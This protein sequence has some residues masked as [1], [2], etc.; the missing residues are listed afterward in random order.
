MKRFMFLRLNAA[1]LAAAA[2]CGALAQAGPKAIQPAPKPVQA[3]SQPAAPGLPS[4]TP[5]P[6]P[7]T[8]LLAGV[9]SQAARLRS[10]PIPGGSQSL[11]QNST[12][13]AVNQVKV[14]H[15]WNGEPNSAGWSFNIG[16][17]K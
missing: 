13:K 16:K 11:H 12:Q 5:R 7:Q 3:L 6:Q 8:D 15:D 4:K 14:L 10:V 9:R 1:L 17:S 2:P